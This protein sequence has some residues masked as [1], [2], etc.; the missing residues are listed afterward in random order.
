MPSIRHAEHCIFCKI[1]RVSRSDREIAFKQHTAKGHVFCHVTIP[2]DI[3]N[4]CGSKSWDHDAEV[5]IDDAV[6][7]EYERLL[8]EANLRE[9]RA[10]EGVEISKIVPIE[11]CQA[12][13]R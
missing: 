5:I 12:L 1:G 6:R 4:H 3:C 7:R 2:M 8:C 11:S 10:N 9:F 13:S